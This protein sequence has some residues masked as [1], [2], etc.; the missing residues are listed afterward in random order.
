MNS[1]LVGLGQKIRRLRQNRGI[2]QE[3]LAFRC[4]LHRTYVTDVEAGTRNLTF[5]SLLAIARGLGISVSE[6]TRNVDS[7]V[8]QQVGKGKRPRDTGPR[9]IRVAPGA[10]ARHRLPTGTR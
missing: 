5:G 6:L 10:R 8:R 4:G 7:S 9:Q 3:E 2:S 1:E